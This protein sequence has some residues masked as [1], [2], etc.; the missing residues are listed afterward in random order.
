MTSLCFLALIT[1]H[2]LI[3]LPS[4]LTNYPSNVQIVYAET[5]NSKINTEA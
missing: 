2:Y 3:S 1:I 5:T 4:N